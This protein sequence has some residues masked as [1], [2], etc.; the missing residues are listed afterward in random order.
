MVTVMT[1]E[2]INSTLFDE[3]EKERT[4][5]AELLAE[6]Q[7]RKRTIADLEYKVEALSVLLAHSETWLLQLRM[8][9]EPDERRKLKEH[10]GNV[11][12]LLRPTEY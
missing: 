6:A 8:K 4:G 10:L 2:Q 11:E 3:L 5:N 1:Q 9:L 7:E 12:R